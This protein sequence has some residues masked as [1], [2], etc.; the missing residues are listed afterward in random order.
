MAH[1]PQEKV[2]TTEAEAIIT[3]VGNSLILEPDAKQTFMENA[4]LPIP[5]IAYIALGSN[6]DNPIEQ[7]KNAIDR[8]QASN[9]C[10]LL[11][12]SSL[13][14]TP[15]WGVTDQPD[16]INA[17]ISIKTALSALELLTICQQ[18]EHQHQRQKTFRWG[19]R[20]LDCDIIHIMG[21][22]CQNDRLT[23]PHPRWHERAF[24]ILPLLEIASNLAIHNLS[25]KKAADALSDMDKAAITKLT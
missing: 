6:L 2:I 17:V 15:P 8:W 9:D 18:I 4:D 7:V 1:P 19:P 13:Y 20:T 24:V 3:D 22:I 25:V 10:E 14:R 12:Q 21:E 11:Q 5:R 23:L 16:F